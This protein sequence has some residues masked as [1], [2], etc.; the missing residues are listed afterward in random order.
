MVSV[1]KITDYECEKCRMRFKPG[2][3]VLYVVKRDG[4]LGYVH[5]ECCLG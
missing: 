5:L 1:F 2:D 4:G 3:T